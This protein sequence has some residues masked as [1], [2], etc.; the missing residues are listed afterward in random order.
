MRTQPHLSK[1]QHDFSCYR[2]KSD[3]GESR[4]IWGGRF[5]KQFETRNLFDSAPCCSVNW[6]FQ[7]AEN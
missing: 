3:T 6:K 5:S 1:I 2:S 7:V 4:G